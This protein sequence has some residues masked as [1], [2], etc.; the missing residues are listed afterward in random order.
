M[1]RIL[2][3]FVI[4][5]SFLFAGN[6]DFECTRQGQFYLVGD[7][8]F[9]NQA[10]NILPRLFGFGYDHT[11]KKD[12]I[13]FNLEVPYKLLHNFNYNDYT[14]NVTYKLTLSGN[15]YAGFGLKN[16]YFD[17]HYV[18]YLNSSPIICFGKDFV[19][20]NYKTFF[21]EGKINFLSYFPFIKISKELDVDYKKT[22]YLKYA[23]FNLSAGI[24]F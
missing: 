22:D 6:Q 9:D 5:V 12:A 8:D 19:K 21:V 24:Y 14:L 4:A 3:F 23:I 7:S 2:P 13:N 1:K 20:T 16:R 10:K 18:R 15:Y 17:M 11:F